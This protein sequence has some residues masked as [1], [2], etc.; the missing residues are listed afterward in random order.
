MADGRSPGFD[1]WES[2]A[3]DPTF[4]CRIPLTAPFTE[5]EPMFD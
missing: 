4:S 3:T 1:I 2:H 5:L